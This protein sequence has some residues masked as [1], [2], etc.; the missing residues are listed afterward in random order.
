MIIVINPY[1]IGL[2]SQFSKIREIMDW[3]QEDLAIAVGVSR[4]VITNIEKSPEKL[5]KAIALALFTVVSGEYKKRCQE[6]ETAINETIWTDENSVR[7]TMKET[8]WGRKDLATIIIT[9]GI[10]M[11]VASLLG[12]AAYGIFA[13]TLKKL[14]SQTPKWVNLTKN[15]IYKEVVI[16]SKVLLSQKEDELLNCFGI[17]KLEPELFLSRINADYIAEL[18]IQN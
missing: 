16:P 15:D 18:D 4:P 8:Y 2:G 3:T 12:L 11:P 5:T 13:G 17:E 9:I 7:K 10:S 1:L 14:I 6:I